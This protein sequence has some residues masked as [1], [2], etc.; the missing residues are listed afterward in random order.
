MQL[1]PH[2]KVVRITEAGGPEVLSLQDEP[3]PEPQ[4]GEVLVRVAAAGVNRPDIQ[5]RRGLYPP[6]GASEIP[7]LDIAGV[8][9]RRDPAFAGGM[10]KLNHHEREDFRLWLRRTQSSFC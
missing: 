10:S 3:R 5:Q 4:T 1:P 9:C 6:P 2:M 8:V 7:G